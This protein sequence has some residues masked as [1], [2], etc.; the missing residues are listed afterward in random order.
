MLFIGKCFKSSYKLMKS[1]FQESEKKK[2][3]NILK[4][5]NNWSEYA[6]YWSR[7]KTYQI[8]FPK[9]INGVLLNAGWM[10]GMIGKK[11]VN[12]FRVHSRGWQNFRNRQFLLFW[13]AWGNIVIMSILGA[14]TFLD[15]QGK[16]FPIT[17]SWSSW[18]TM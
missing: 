15:M 17:R 13:Q 4:L 11:I 7:K 12:C 5:D 2:A 9:S 6:Y 8:Y 14:K 18:N 16:E 10:L 3:V 1:E